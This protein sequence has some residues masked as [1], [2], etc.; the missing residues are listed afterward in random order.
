MWSEI[1]I[2]FYCASSQYIL[3]VCK[4]GIFVDIAD[5]VQFIYFI[6]H[7][8]LALLHDLICYCY[9]EEECKIPNLLL[10]VLPIKWNFFCF[11]FPPF[12]YKLV[13]L[14]TH[15]TFSAVIIS[16]SFYQVKNLILSREVEKCEKFCMHFSFCRRLLLPLLLHFK[17]STFLPFANFLRSSHISFRYNFI[18]CEKSFLSSS[19]LAL[20]CAE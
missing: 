13:H 11:S 2:L 7:D 16:L 12:T 17:R 20:L 5:C 15:R 3:C 14:F 6:H 10:L 8:I 18:D 1:A 9:D 4:L 19:A